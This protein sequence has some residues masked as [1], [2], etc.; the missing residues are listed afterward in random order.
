MDVTLERM[1]ALVAT[2]IVV[3]GNVREICGRNGID[4]DLTRLF[5]LRFLID[6]FKS[7]IL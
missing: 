7:V 1:M 5:Y 2:V 4:F 6:V 3:F